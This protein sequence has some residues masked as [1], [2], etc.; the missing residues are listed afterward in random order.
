LTG[1]LKELTAEKKISPHVI[2]AAKTSSPFNPQIEQPL[3]STNPFLYGSAIPVELFIGRTDALSAIR[4]R[5]WSPWGLQSLSIVSNRR[6]GKTSLLNY[7]AKKHASIFP[8]EQAYVTVY[9]D[10]MDARAQTV[11]GVMRLL[12]RG[13]ARQLQ[14]DLWP[15]ADDGNQVA[16]SDA[17]EK[18]AEDEK[19]RLV[20]LLDE[21]ESVMAFPNLDP[22]LYNLRSC[23]SQPWIGMITATAHKLID[24]EAQ[25]GLGSEFYNIF[26]TE[27]LGN[28]PYE[29]WRHLVEQAYARSGRGVSSQVI[30]QIGH[31]AGGH[32]YLTQLAGSLHWQAEETGWN[33]TKIAGKFSERACMIFTNIW[34]RLD[35]SQI[36]ALRY[37]MG[38]K[39]VPEAPLNVVNDLKARGVL[40]AAGEV[41]CQPFAD[42]ILQEVG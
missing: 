17:F 12:R 10:A 31:L 29:E 6:M 14:R 7:V 41:F 40:T 19:I 27:Y 15:E 13:I 34:Q 3:T 8:E 23:G 32:P 38:T 2:E 21:F 4:D 35:T 22:L 11:A 20:L 37:A 18:L 42:F 24:L 39:G 26:E 5:V 33:V 28:M 9:I 25:G 30:E 16:M 36:Q 1:R